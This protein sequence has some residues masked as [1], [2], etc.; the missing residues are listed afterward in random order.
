M[1]KGVATTG[2]RKSRKSH[3]SGR[4]GGHGHGPLEKRTHPAKEK[5]P[6]R[7]ETAAK[8]DVGAACFRKCRAQF[9]IAKGAQKSTMKQTAGSMRPKPAWRSPRRVPCRWLTRKTPVPMVSPMTMAVA[10]H[11][12]RPRTKS[13]RS[14]WSAELAAIDEELRAYYQRQGW[15]T[16]SIPRLSSVRAECSCL[17]WFCLEV[18]A[19]IEA[20]MATHEIDA[21]R[22]SLG[23]ALSS[24]GHRRRPYS[25][26]RGVSG[27]RCFKHCARPCICSA[28]TPI[29]GVLTL[30]PQSW[31][32][33][34]AC[35]SSVA[36]GISSVPPRSNCW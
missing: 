36:S 35:W 2:N 7:A 22:I 20:A 28:A 15:S 11:R 9:G 34:S 21:E 17:R 13:D 8:V 29:A 12:P 6:E 23:R 10:D 14:E 4:Q 32:T 24:G 27:D 30:R 5:S 33:R 3:E 26:A 16:D 1:N 25:R 18:R 31:P 19:I